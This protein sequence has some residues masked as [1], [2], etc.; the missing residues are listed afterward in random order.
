M[1]Q[2][3]RLMT[4]LCT[5]DLPGTSD[6][7]VELFVFE[8]AFDSDWFV[9][10]VASD[11]GL[12]LGLIDQQHELVPPDFRNPPSG[13]Y[14]TLV[15]EDVDQLHEAAQ[16]SNVPIVAPPEDTFYGQRRMLIQDPAGTL[17][18]VSSP[19]PDFTFT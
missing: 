5:L 10:L 3:K 6:F 9:Q 11:T 1:A 4:T 16:Q 2:I 15:V 14:L 7:Y 13:A 12:E 8:V 19:I 17:I 18:D